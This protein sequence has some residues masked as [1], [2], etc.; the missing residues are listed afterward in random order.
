MQPIHIRCG[1]A[2]VHHRCANHNESSRPQLHAGGSA[3]ASTASH[4]VDHHRGRSR[5]RGRQPGSAAIHHG[6]HGQNK[7]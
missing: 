5:R 6:S 7:S 4:R 2:P 1:R 3:H